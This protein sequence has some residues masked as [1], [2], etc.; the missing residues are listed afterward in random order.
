M[1]RSL[2]STTL[3]AAGVIL[4]ALVYT[5]VE[6]TTTP[7]PPNFVEPHLRAIQVD[8]QTVNVSIADTD[9]TRQKGLSGRSGLAPNEGMLFI[10]S[11]D[12]KYTFWMKDMKFSIDILW[13]EADPSNPS[14]QATIVSM[15]QSVSPD[16]Y[17]RDFLPS[18]PVRYVLELPAGFAEQYNVRIGD[19]VQL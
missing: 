3:L 14:G 19:T 15:A 7:T 8:G 4:V 11:Q 17:P 16:T 2:I 12:R 5:R 10:F 18:R 6:F 13:L 9:A 1:K